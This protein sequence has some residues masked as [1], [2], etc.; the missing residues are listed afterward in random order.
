ME[1]ANTF[2]DLSNL[3]KE[4]FENFFREA[5]LKGY[6]QGFEQAQRDANVNNEYLSF[7]QA[8]ELVSISRNTLSKWIELGLPTYAIDGKKIIKRS[9]LQKFISQHKIN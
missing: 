6:Q 9:E 2:D 8:A 1:N 7:G 4:A 3:F 5:T